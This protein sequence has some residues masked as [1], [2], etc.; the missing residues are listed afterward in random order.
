[1]LENSVLEERGTQKGDETNKVP[2]PREALGGGSRRGLP[3]EVAGIDAPEPEDQVH[4]VAAQVE[5]DEPGEQ[6]GTKKP[7]H[8]IR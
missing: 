8:S 3:R 6:V 7:I 5:V 1:M 2:S 4:Q